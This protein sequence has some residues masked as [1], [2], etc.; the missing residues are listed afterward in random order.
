MKNDVLAFVAVVVA[1]PT[2]HDGRIPSETW[3]SKGRLEVT[4][5]IKHVLVL[6]I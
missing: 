1:K 3:R 4:R 2:K 6:N 5:K